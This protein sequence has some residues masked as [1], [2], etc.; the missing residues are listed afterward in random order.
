MCNY[1]D[2]AQPNKQKNNDKAFFC[3]SRELGLITLTQTTLGKRALLDP[4]RSVTIPTYTNVF[5]ECIHIL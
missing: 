4:K 2:P 1:S 3:F 5:S